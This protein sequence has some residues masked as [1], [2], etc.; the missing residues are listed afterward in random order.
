MEAITK[1]SAKFNIRLIGLRSMSKEIKT[2]LRV[3]NQKESNGSHIIIHARI[4]LRGV[5]GVVKS[6]IRPPVEQM[7]FYQTF[8]IVLAVVKICEDIICVIF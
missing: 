8:C 5:D 7:C 1:P 4:K 3:S 2:V 6:D